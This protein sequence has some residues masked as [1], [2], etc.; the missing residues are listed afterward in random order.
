MQ[1]PKLFK[2][3]NPPIEAFGAFFSDRFLKGPN[4]CPK[5]NSIIQKAFTLALGHL[6]NGE[7][8]GHLRN[9]VLALGMSG[10]ID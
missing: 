7:Y 9:V 5:N 4:T 2:F 10:S 1:M 8:S 6:S 3:P